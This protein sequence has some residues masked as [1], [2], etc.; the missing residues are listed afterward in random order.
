MNLYLIPILAIGIFV[1][2]MRLGDKM[3]ARIAFYICFAII[4]GAIEYPITGNYALS[5]TVFAFGC[6]WYVVKWGKDI[7]MQLRNPLLH[8]SPAVRWVTAA[9]ILQ[10]ILVRASGGYS[11]ELA[12]AIVVFLLGLYNVLLLLKKP[13]DDKFPVA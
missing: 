12:Q 1:Q 2:S 6:V 5:M 4:S 3:P 9:Y 10:D 8:V 11:I 13:S 7:N